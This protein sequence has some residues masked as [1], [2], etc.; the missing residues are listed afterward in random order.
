MPL[1][2]ISSFIDLTITRPLHFQGGLRAAVPP[3]T[4]ADVLTPFPTFGP[5]TYCAAVCCDDTEETCL[6]AD[7]LPESCASIADGGC[8]CEEGEEKCDADFANGVPGYC[9]PKGFCCDETE[10]ECWD[11][12]T[13]APVS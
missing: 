7:Y 9:A 3:P 11:T 6:G 4:P 1:C 13:C 12:L 5:Y 2:K 8:P 10:D